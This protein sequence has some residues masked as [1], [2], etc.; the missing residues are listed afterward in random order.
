MPFLVTSSCIFGDVTRGP[1]QFSAQSV[2]LIHGVNNHLTEIAVIGPNNQYGLHLTT[3]AQN[4]D[5]VPVTLSKVDKGIMA[6]FN[7]F[8]HTGRDTTLSVPVNQPAFSIDDT[9][10]VT[11]N[12]IDGTA[13]TETHRYTGINLALVENGTIMTQSNT[14]GVIKTANKTPDAGF[15]QTFFMPASLGVTLK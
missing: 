3:K 7:H 8:S 10:K 13:N 5:D 9:K 6:A 2:T 15:A 11:V 1:I 4:S 14:T 12:I